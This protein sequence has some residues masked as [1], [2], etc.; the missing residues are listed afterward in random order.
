MFSDPFHI[1]LDA[2]LLLSCTRIVNMA[3]SVTTVWVVS[4]II[5]YEGSMILEICTSNEVAV[6]FVERH[7]A[8]LGDN[9][10]L[11]DGKWLWR[12]VKIKIHPW[13]LDCGTH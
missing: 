12:D 8:Q 5:D 9:Y 3:G 1:F 6:A 7:I 10:V 2:D 11:K 4:K 13:E